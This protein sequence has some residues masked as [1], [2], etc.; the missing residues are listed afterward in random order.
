[1]C[2]GAIFRFGRIVH[3]ARRVRETLN[4]IVKDCGTP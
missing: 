3:L 1:M 2:C 4:A